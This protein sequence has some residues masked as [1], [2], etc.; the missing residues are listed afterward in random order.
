MFEP[1]GSFNVT[2]SLYRLLE[3]RP[4]CTDEDIT[5]AYRKLALKYHPDKAGGC[6]YKFNQLKTAHDI[7]KDPHKREY[8]DRFGDSG[9]KLVCPTNGSPTS[10]IVDTSTF[11][12]RAVLKILSRPTRLVPFFLVI[13]FINICFALFMYLLDKK[14]YFGGLKDVP[15]YAIFS[16]L[17]IYLV[18]F[19]LL[20]GLLTFI[21]I[22]NFKTFIVSSFNS[23]EFSQISEPRRKFHSFITA[24][25]FVFIPAAI[26]ILVLLFIYCTSLMAIYFGENGKL[27]AGMT[28]SKLYYPLTVCENLTSILI[29]IFSAVRV[30]RFQNPERLWTERLIYLVGCAFM[31]A[32]VIVYNYFIIQF[33]DTG[34]KPLLIGAYSIFYLSVIYSI[35]QNHYE[36]KWKAEDLIKALIEKNGE[37]S[38][39]EINSSVKKNLR[40]QRKCFYAAVGIFLIDLV[41]QNLHFAGYWPKTWS[42][43]YL[44]LMI[45]VYA[46]IFVFGVALPVTMSLMD[47]V[48]PPNSFDSFDS[49]TSP[50]EEGITVIEIPTRIYK[51]GFGFAPLQP[52]IRS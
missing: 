33:F 10:D 4:Q 26:T 50:G 21:S 12:G 51:F 46:S 29:F 32:S 36:T 17:W 6:P 15:W 28:W 9:L 13:A 43:A 14:I 2:Y 23:P 41:L 1:D 7:L 40:F 45:F 19:A 31:S 34:D 30:I 24:S 3:L 22:N 5:R 48:I 39:A 35:F 11:F 27:T 18:S 38:Q 8:Y 42:M 37:E 49:S 47:F 16:L 52:R 25:F 20:F 44:V